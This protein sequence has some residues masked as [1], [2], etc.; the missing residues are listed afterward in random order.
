VYDCERKTFCIRSCRSRFL[1]G[2]AFSRL[3]QMRFH[4][5]GNVR[6]IRFVRTARITFDIV[7]AEVGTEVLVDFLMNDEI[8]DAAGMIFLL[9]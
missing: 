8:H 7:D 4:G 2:G 6:S 9:Q 3:F 5:K 1:R